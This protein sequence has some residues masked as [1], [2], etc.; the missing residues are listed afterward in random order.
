[1]LPRAVQS[2]RHEI[3]HQVVTTRH[4]VKNVIDHALLALERHLPEAEVGVFARQRH[5]R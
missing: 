1:M 5:S 2:A 3:V 4:A